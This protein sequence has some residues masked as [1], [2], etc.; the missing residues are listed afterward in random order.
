L[1]LS[2]FASISLIFEFFSWKDDIFSV[3]FFINFNQICAIILL[4]FV[5]RI[6]FNMVK[7]ASFEWPL[8]IFYKN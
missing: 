4:V 2:A 6:L 3:N 1:W 7:L 5:W 8:N